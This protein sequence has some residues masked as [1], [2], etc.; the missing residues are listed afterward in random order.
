MRIVAAVVVGAVLLG[1]GHAASAAEARRQRSERCLE[2]CNFTFEQCQHDESSKAN[3]RCDIDAVRCKNACPYVTIEEPAVPTAMSNARCVEACRDTYKKCTGLAANKR[4][5]NCAADDL[6]CEHACPK[7]PEPP[8]AGAPGSPEG[9]A[10]AAP[11]TPLHGNRV[12]GAAAPAPIG[13][14]P[15]VAPKERAAGTAEHAVSASERAESAGEQPVASGAATRS[16]SAVEPAPEGA[17][18]TAAAR[19]APAERGFFATLKCFFVACEPAGSSPCLL[20][21]A[22]A[23]DQCKVRESKRGG[24]C[25]TRLM[26]CRRGCEAAPTPAR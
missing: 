3:G 20:Q 1:S 12:E 22:N 4:G 23:Y 26:N 16:E 7:P 19:P 14:T 15:I 8:V 5:G 6:R 10:A 17:A 25:N 11:K 2:I 13:P 18:A 21:C 9:A 24:E